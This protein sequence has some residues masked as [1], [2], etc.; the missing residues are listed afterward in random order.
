MVMDHNA[1]RDK[2]Q[3]NNVDYSF[4]REMC[5]EKCMDLRFMYDNNRAW[6]KSHDQ[7]LMDVLKRPSI[8]IDY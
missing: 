5:Y 7:E 2:R 3:K 6:R 8:R 4:L 1:G